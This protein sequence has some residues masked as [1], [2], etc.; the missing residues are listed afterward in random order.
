ME[1]VK[2]WKLNPAK[3]KLFLETFKYGIPPE[4]GFALGAE[5]MTMQILELSNVR[6]ASIFPRD[7][8]RID[9]RLTSKKR[10]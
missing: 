5:R 6:E 8:E 3:I 9:E 4:G 2:K 10:S 7:I 1:H